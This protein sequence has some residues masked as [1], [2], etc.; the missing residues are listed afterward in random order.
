MKVG[1]GVGRL[2]SSN[3]PEEGSEGVRQSGVCY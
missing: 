1:G 2:G 3:K